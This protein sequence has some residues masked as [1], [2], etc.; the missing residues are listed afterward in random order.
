MDVM[1]NDVVFGEM[2]YKR[3][4]SK[5]ETFSFFGKDWK[6]TVVA[7][8]FSG[9]PISD[10]QRVSYQWLKENLKQVD[11]MLY[12]MIS[13]YIND[14]CQEFSVYWSGARM[15]NTPSDLARIIDLKTILIKQDG[16]TLVLSDCPWD[17]HGVAIQLKPDVEIGSQDMF[18]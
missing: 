3:R 1:V 13:G 17:E 18:L 11:E 6:M 12:E 7:K 8:A 15:V 16:T 5:K 2:I 14:N 10:E 9:K 4:W